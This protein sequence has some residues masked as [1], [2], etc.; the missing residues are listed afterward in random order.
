MQ[1]ALTDLGVATNLPQA[2]ETM[3]LNAVAAVTSPE[4]ERGCM[5]SSGMVNSAKEHSDLA[6]ELATRR[7]DMRHSISKALLRWIDRAHADP[8]ARYLVTVLQG[9]SVQA[10]DGATHDELKPVVDQVSAGIRA[11]LALKPASQNAVVKD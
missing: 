6:R 2:V 5:V 9:L 10:R 7:D 1:G 11:T 8:L 3:L 4:G